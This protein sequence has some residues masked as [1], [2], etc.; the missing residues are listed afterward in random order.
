MDQVSHSRSLLISYLSTI[1]ISD[2][3]TN[4]PLTG[5]PCLSSKWSARQQNTS[6][7]LSHCIRMESGRG[8]GDCF[9]WYLSLRGNIGS[10]DVSRPAYSLRRLPSYWICQRLYLLMPTPGQPTANSITTSELRTWQEAGVYLY[11]KSQ[12]KTATA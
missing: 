9:A 12:T 3:E 5:N 6:G 1:I 2:T 10:V 8:G 11:P 4:M 7:G